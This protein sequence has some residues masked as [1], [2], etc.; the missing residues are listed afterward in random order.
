MK[1]ILTLLCLF[2]A[3]SASAQTEGTDII[4]ED[5][6]QNDFGEFIFDMYSL[7]NSDLLTQ[8]VWDL[9]LFTL[10]IDNTK[11]LRINPNA[12]TF[13]SGLQ[14]MGNTSSSFQPMLYPG[15]AGNIQW[16]GASYRLQNGIRI[17]TYGE[18]DSDGYKRANPAAL[19]WQRNNFNAAF[20]MRSSNGKFGIKVEVSAG[21]GY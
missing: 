4:A 8:P 3:L 9:G 15:R 21:R 1:R 7:L 13:K 6:R 10:P 18:Y 11:G 14:L 16:Q 12:F 20:E 19:P 5:N 2:V 17:N